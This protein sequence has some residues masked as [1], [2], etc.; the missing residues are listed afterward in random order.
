MGNRCMVGIPAAGRIPGS[1]DEGSTPEPQSASVESSTGSSIKKMDEDMPSFGDL[2]LSQ[3]QAGD[4]GVTKMVSKV[5]RGGT[6]AATSHLSCQMATS[7][8]ASGR[9]M[10]WCANAKSEAPIF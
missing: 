9:T 10:L 2:F 6:R 5:G 3:G 7:Q 4:E 8:R 1:R